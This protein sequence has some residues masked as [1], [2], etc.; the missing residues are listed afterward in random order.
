VSGNKITL[1]YAPPPP[2]HPP[3]APPP[4]PSPPPGSPFLFAASTFSTCG[5]SGRIGPSQSNCNTAYASTP[6]AGAVTVTSG[7]QTWTVPA[8][9]TFR[10]TATGA[11]GG[12]STGNNPSYPGRGALARG[13][14]ELTLG[15]V[16]RILVGHKGDD[17]ANLGG[18]GGGTYVV[19]G[20]TG[21]TALVVAGGGGGANKC[22]NDQTGP[23]SVSCPLSSYAVQSSEGRTDASTTTTAYPATYF[24][25]G[26]VPGAGGADGNGGLIGSGSGITCR[27]GAGGGLL[28]DGADGSAGGGTAGG[29]AF[30]NGGDGSAKSGSQWADGGFG[31]GSGS[32]DNCLTCSGA[33]GG[34]SGGGAAA[35]LGSGGGGSSYVSS[36]ASNPQ[37]QA[38]VGTGHGSVLIEPAS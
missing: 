25:S 31:G 4:S 14:F 26:Y 23:A 1:P 34:Y 36:S 33:G 30:V 29:H 24:H 35:S 38:S 6:L 21:S 2:P 18:G 10:I 3:S 11:A 37:L 8:T 27:C 16:L 15:Q 5:Q 7:I 13:D 12:D 19:L 22:T 20:A 9:G 17:A 28:T 32:N